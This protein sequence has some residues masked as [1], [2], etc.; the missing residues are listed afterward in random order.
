M[1]AR[2]EVLNVHLASILSKLGLP[3][4]AERRR[5]YIPDV[6]ISHHYLGTILAEAEVGDTWD[7]EVAEERLRTMVDQRFRQRHF[8]HIDLILLIVYPK[9][10]IRQMEAISE[11]KIEDELANAEIGMGIAFRK[12]LLEAAFDFKWYPTQVGVTQ[13]PSALEQITK[14]IVVATPEEITKGLSETI[15]EAG[16]T[17]ASASELKEAF[18]EKAPDLDID[19]E[20]FENA[21]DC[22]NLTI[23]TMFTLG[24]VGLLIYELAR[25]RHPLA[26]QDLSS[27]NAARM[28]EGLR[29]LRKINY[30]EIIDSSI[31]A[32]SNM[33]SHPQLNQFLNAIHAQIKKAVDPIRRGGWD[34]L[35]FIYQRLLSETYRKAYA[36][37]YTKLPAAYLLAN[38]AVES[39]N[40]K[41]I[42][43]ACGTGS[44]LVSA[45]FVKK[46][47]TLK[48][49]NIQRMLD[50]KI[51]EPIL[52]YVNKRMLNDVYGLD[53][54]DTAVSLSSGVL[55]LASSA[56]PR[57]RL[58]LFN[59]PVGPDKSGSLDLLR[60]STIKSDGYG[61]TLRTKTEEKYE[62]AENQFDVVI[63]NPPFTRSDR[64]PTLI[65]DRARRDLNSLNLKLGGVKT[66]NLFVA[67][68]AKP[69]LVLGDR[70]CANG[71]R[72]AAV[73]PN[74]L[75]SRDA[76]IDV[77]QGIVNSYIIDDVVVSYAP[78]TPNFSSDTQFREILLVVR[79]E[80]GKRSKSKTRIVNL[81]TRIDDLKL[82]EIDALVSNIRE[83][84]KTILLPERNFEVA[85]TIREFDWEVIRSIADN[86]YRL[87]AF[88][89]LDLTEHHLNLIKNYCVPFGNYFTLGSVVDHTN[90]LAVAR[91]R[92][93]GRNYDAAWGSGENSGIHTMRASPHH[94]LIVRD[95][96]AV[97]CKLWEDD[98]RSK[99]MILRRGQLDTQYI[100][101]F[102]LD[103]EAVSNVWWPFWPTKKLKAEHVTATLTFMNSILGFTHVLG[104][105]LETR[106]L[107]ME[108][109]KGQLGKMP[110]PAFEKLRT[111]KLQEIFEARNLSHIETV[112]LPKVGTYIARMA[113]LEADVGDYS[114]AIKQ[115][116]KDPSLKARAALDQ[117]SIDLL[118]LLGCNSIPEKIYELV[119]DEIEVLRGI[120]ESEERSDRIRDK[121]SRAI[122][123]VADKSQRKLDIWS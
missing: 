102:R 116:L 77:R 59:A 112:P 16:K 51:K 119:S 52:D 89:N 103:R 69:F 17:L 61:I 76:W 80:T 101:M 55:T 3:S 7:D 12:H 54:L 104:E 38:L 107:W 73:L 86:W 48:P 113:K 88:R 82:H 47:A 95:E 78:G 32:W 74:S 15:E 121:G 33:P 41:I 45:F 75:L 110:T 96:D 10:L 56:V 50:K 25:T 91:R 94:F 115:A 108:L 66:T 92:L 29:R 43:P 106:G 20:I 53:A 84:K 71:G 6:I 23:K 1:A 123:E 40:D 63:M 111:A 100:L 46:K 18:L 62:K 120:M 72:I 98:Y 79:K 22:L 35:A 4:Q 68:L 24:G 57:S 83:G 14:D 8:A 114:R 67:G 27:L 70:L 99:L 2:Q 65:G 122:R 21:N 11:D 26:L 36:T 5:Q 19:P 58:K 117:V 49:K 31:M 30:V 60:T 42:D 13:I 105:R 81:F 39:A 109:K 9:K 85:A 28:L 87:A 44:L 93:E 118:S 97:K 37:F 64:I 34:V 90:G